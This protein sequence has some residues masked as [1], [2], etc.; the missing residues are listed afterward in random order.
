MSCCYDVPVHMMAAAVEVIVSLGTKHSVFHVGIVTVEYPTVCG[1]DVSAAYDDSL[2]YV[3]V[4]C[5]SLSSS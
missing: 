2:I 3:C 1:E 4:H 5:E